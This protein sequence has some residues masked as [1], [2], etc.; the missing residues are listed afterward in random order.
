MPM[1]FLTFQVIFKSKFFRLFKYMPSKPDFIVRHRWIHFLSKSKVQIHFSLN[2]LTII[3][4]ILFL[5]SWRT[6]FDKKK[7]LFVHF[8]FISKYFV[9]LKI[10][11]RV[12]TQTKKKKKFAE[13]F[14]K[15][16][17]IT[18]RIFPSFLK[19]SV[20]FYFS[21]TEFRKFSAV[22]L[23][24]LSF[25]YERYRDQLPDIS[26]RTF[27]K[28]CFTAGNT[29]HVLNTNTKSEQMWVICL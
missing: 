6:R 25:V 4:T 17:R 22:V 5:E 14:L 26:Q 8:I 27:R 19:T 29:V 10:Y 9:F 20:V 11:L 18:D 24:F 2:V 1:K 12:V 7:F 15:I 3:R 28:L 23:I 21:A 16:C 13:N